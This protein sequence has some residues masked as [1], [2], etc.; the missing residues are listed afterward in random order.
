MNEYGVKAHTH[1]QR[2][3][4]RERE[5]E[6]F[7][8]KSCP[9]LL[10]TAEITRLKKIRLRKKKKKRKKFSWNENRKIDDVLERLLLKTVPDKLI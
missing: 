9:E 10:P 2:E 7:D 3:R 6:S 1:I 4:E 8:E 5:R